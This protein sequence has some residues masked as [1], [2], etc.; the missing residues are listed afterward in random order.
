MSGTQPRRES[1]GTS[2]SESEIDKVILGSIVNLQQM[3]KERAQLKDDP[4]MNFCLDVASRLRAMSSHQKALVKLQ[5]QQV[6]FSVECSF[7]AA[8]SSHY[9][10]PPQPTFPCTPQQL[11][12]MNT[13]SQP[14]FSPCSD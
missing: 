6:L 5:I 14:P 12:L 13:H 1:D 7:E 10:P 8:S 3:D 4:E 2:T 11:P 9:V